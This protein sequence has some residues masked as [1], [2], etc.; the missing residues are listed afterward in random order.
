MPTSTSRMLCSTKAT[1]F[2]MFGSTIHSFI[3]SH[4]LISFITSLILFTRPPWSG[5]NS[6]GCSAPR[7]STSVGLIGITPLCSLPAHSRMPKLE[8]SASPSRVARKGRV[9]EACSNYCRRRNMVRISPRDRGCWS[10]ESFMSGAQGQILLVHAR[11]E[12][13]DGCR[14][15]PFRFVMSVVSCMQLC[16]TMTSIL[17]LGLYGLYSATIEATLNIF[18]IQSCPSNS[19]VTDYRDWR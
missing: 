16:I 10:R 13:H 18:S 11:Y 6:A 4:Y 14:Y 1:S 17:K 9:G 3:V 7:V 12:D 19:R 2:G 5:Q 8:G 15:V